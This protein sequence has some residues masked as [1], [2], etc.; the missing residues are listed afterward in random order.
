M[1]KCTFVMIFLLM[2]SSN[3]ADASIVYDQPIDPIG[4]Y[5]YTSNYG[6]QNILEDFTISSKAKVNRVSWYGLFSSGTS[7]TKQS[8]AN[9][10]IIFFM[11][12]PSIAAIEPNSGRIISGLPVQ[13]PFYEFQS[14]AVYGTETGILDMLHGGDIYKWTVDIPT[15]SFIDSSKYWIDIRASFNETDFFLWE[16]SDGVFDTI[17]VHPSAREF[18]MVPHFPFYKDG[19]LVYQDAASYWS[20]NISEEYYN[21]AQAFSL[22]YI[23]IPEPAT[24]FLLGLSLLVLVRFKKRLRT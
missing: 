18:P 1:K 5:G 22:E 2:L 12:D 11:S 19:E 21:T 4:Q 23:T 15:V 10:D 3:L 7:A 20:R 24:V 14:V 17:A 16:H 9:F 8:V 13:T 6:K